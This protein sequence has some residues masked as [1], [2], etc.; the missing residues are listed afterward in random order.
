MFKILIV[1]DHAPFRQSLRGIISAKFP[2]LRIQEAGDGKEVLQNLASFLPDLVFMDINLPDTTGLLLTKDI[3]A[4][5]PET[6]IIVL[7]GYDLPEYRD[8]AYQAGADYFFSK[9]STNETELTDTIQ[10]ILT[11][12][13]GS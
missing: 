4:D 5:H 10:S 2:S 3:K 12:T 9:D 13:R 6:N 7:T 11:N 1:D 8:A